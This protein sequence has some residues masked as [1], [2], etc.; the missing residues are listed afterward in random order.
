MTQLP[1]GFGFYLA[2]AFASNAKLATDFFEGPEPTIFQTETEDDDL[3]F[4]FG[5]FVQRVGN[6]SP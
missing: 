3:P 5:E 4:A 6:L 2:D 1:Q